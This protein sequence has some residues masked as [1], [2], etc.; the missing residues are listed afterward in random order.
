[1]AATTA[2][3]TA[4]ISVMPDA[5]EVGNT[6]DATG[7][8]LAAIEDYKQQRIAARAALANSLG[9]DFAN[10]PPNVEN[11]IAKE[12]AWQAQDQALAA[13][14]K[15]AEDLLTIVEG[16]IDVLEA[17]QPEALCTVLQAKIAQLEAAMAAQE[18]QE[19]SLTERIKRLRARL[20][21]VGASTTSKKH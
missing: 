5:K 15:A 9:Q 14:I 11:A 2:T 1:M 6:I 4:P 18:D 10:A 3:A 7:I 16:Q 19:K 13:K 21:K 12:T 20:H 17:M 8:F